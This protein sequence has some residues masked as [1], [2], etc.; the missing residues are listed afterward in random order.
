MLKK[1]AESSLV[2][3]DLTR[4]THYMCNVKKMIP[5]INN[6]DRW[7]NLKINQKIPEQ[8]TGKA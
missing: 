7:N 3:I 5:V 6:R 2:Y 1:E 8:N 4:E